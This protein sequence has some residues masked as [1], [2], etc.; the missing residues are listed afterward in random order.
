MK[1]LDNPYHNAIHASDVLNSLLYFITHSHLLDDI[2]LLETFSC[3]MAALGHDVSHPALNNKYLITTRDKLA[4]RYNDISVLENMHAATIFSLLKEPDCDILKGLT[5]EDYGGLRKITVE[6]VLG[7]DMSRHFESYNRF[8]A[9]LSIAHYEFNS[10]D[11]RIFVLSVGLK[12]ADIG[13]SAKNIELHSKWTERICAE[14]FHQGDLEK[15]N[16]LPVSMWFDRENT[17]VAKSQAGFLRHICLPLYEEW[18]KYL[19]SQDIE[20]TCL[21]QLRENLAYWESFNYAKMKTTSERD[22]AV[23]SKSYRQKTLK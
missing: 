21:E 17:N 3:F 6:M 1:Y 2:T 15:A 16:G 12:C 11:D 13:H 23:I 18:V 8:K 14:F 7:T 19:S 4:I 5:A 9:K 10:F 22:S 20:E